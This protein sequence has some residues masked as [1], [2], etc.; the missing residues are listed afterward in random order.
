MPEKT[1]KLLKEWYVSAMDTIE[2][3]RDFGYLMRLWQS[4]PPDHKEFM[5]MVKMMS[6]TGLEGWLDRHSLG[7]DKLAKELGAD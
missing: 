4:H 1:N 7:L 5:V 6:F 2:V 3:L